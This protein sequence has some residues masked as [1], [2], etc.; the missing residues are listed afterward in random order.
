M[1]FK[2][3]EM[4]ELKQSTSEIKEAVV[5]ISA[6]LN[7]HQR[8]ELYF[9]IGPDGAVKGQT[10]GR[11]TLRDVSQ[12]IAAN[13][14]PKIYPQITKVRIDSKDCIHVEFQGNEIPYYAYGRA[15]MRTGDENR[16]LSAKALEAIILQKNK[17][18]LR[19]DTAICSD[20]KIKDI[21]AQK[22]KRFLDVA[23]IKYDTARNSLKKLKLMT[24]G[25]LLNAAVLL[26]GNKPQ[27]FFQNA[28][29]RCAVFG[30]NDTSFTLD[31]KDF[32]G[33]LFNLIEQAQAYIL[34]NIHI[35]MQLQGLRRID[36]PEIDRE[37]FREAI[38]NAFCHRDYFAYDSVNIAI[39]KNRVEIRN[40][41]LLFGGLTIAQI[42]R[43]MVSERRNELIAEMLHRAHFIEKWGRGIRLILNK[44]PA[45]EL[46]EIGSHFAV[47]F[48]RK[49][50]EKEADKIIEKLGERL[51]V[52]LGVKLG[53]NE[54]RILELIIRNKFM[55]IIQISK[56]LHISTTAVEKNLA[57][58]KA[59]KLL[60][61]IGSDKKGYW[62]VRTP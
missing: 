23:G 47:I 42:R 11:N 18:K 8:G 61:R 34:E 57:K 2:E 21:N 35:G 19:W 28:K 6:I 49:H 16:Q 27:S 44:E 60:S 50:V 17:D 51:G 45:T 25:K 39:F 56:E 37:A 26:F 36:E 3:T 53:V 55:T 52:K 38:I 41:G 14:E 9:G 4:L 7:K 54:A 10:V 48:R 33:D 12:A 24:N 29:L 13:I 30:S 22:V 58:L 1:K 59:K 46:K 32:E 40:P 43:E 20:A 62:K 31:M 5:S 15:Y